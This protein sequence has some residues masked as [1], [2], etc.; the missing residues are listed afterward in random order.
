MSVSGRGPRREERTFTRYVRALDPEGNPPDEERFLLLWKTLRAALRSELKKR[1]LWAGSP[2]YVGIYGWETWAA[3][4]PPSGGDHERPQTALDELVGECYLFVFVDRLR[5]LRAQLQLKPNIDGLI[6]LSLRHFLYERQRE[7]DPVGYRVFEVARAAVRRAVARQ[8]LQVWAGDP[9]I[10]NDTLLGWSAPAGAPPGRIERPRVGPW[11]RELMPDL[12]AARGRAL[13]AVI[14]RLGE[15]IV[16]LRGEGLEAFFFRDLID[17]LKSAV[18]EHWAATLAG[19]LVAAGSCPASA[20]I[21]LPQ[22]A[23]DRLAEVQSYE[24]LTSCMER[25]LEGLDA[26]DRTRRHLSALWRYLCS[27]AEEAALGGEGVA[28]RDLAAAWP[29]SQRQIAERLQIPRDRLPALFAALRQL[30][31]A[32]RAAE[33]VRIAAAERRA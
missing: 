22:S 4:A 25:R 11:I 15:R 23:E 26:D 24:R 16:E 20:G 30:I 19:F 2:R 8:S 9:R 32:C 21:S 7:H 1:G 13:A 29:A 3:S 28:G 33:C 17:P 5:S 31:E 27:Q 10:R 12:V 14:E 6:F 18:R